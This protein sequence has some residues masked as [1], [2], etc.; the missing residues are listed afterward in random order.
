MKRAFMIIG[1]VFLLSIF[2]RF[3]FG[4]TVHHV[5]TAAE[6]HNAL[7]A[8]ATNGDDDNIQVAIGTY[9]GNFQCTVTDG[10]DI[11]LS[12]GYSHDFYS[13]FSSPSLTVLDGGNLDKVLSIR[14][15][16]GGSIGVWRFT[17][18]NGQYTHSWYRSYGAGISAYAWT[19]IDG[20][21]S[22]SIFIADNIIIGNSVT[23]GFGGGVY[24]RSLSEKGPTGYIYIDNNIIA[25]NTAK[26]RGGGIEA[27]V[28]SMIGSHGDV[29]FEGNTITANACTDFNTDAG[30]ARIDG[31]NCFV[32]N[33]IIW[34]N[35]ALR[36]GDLFISG[37]YTSGHYNDYDPAKI[38]GTWT[39]EGN[40]INVDPLFVGGGD[41]HLLPNS[42][43]IDAGN[44]LS[45][46]IYDF[47][48]NLRIID[49]NRDGKAKEDIGA[50]EYIPIHEFDGHDFDGNGTSDVSVWRPYDGKWYIRGMT[51]IPWGIQGDIPVNGY[52]NGDSIT[53]IA[54]WRPSNG[55]WY[56]RGV[57]GTNWG[58]AGDIPVPADYNGDGITEKAVWRPSNGRWYVQG[59]GS[60]I[61]GIH[62]DIPVPGDYNGDGISEI[63]V[64][65]PSNGR[66]YIRGLGGTNW[67]Q[68]GD[69]PVPADYNGD[70]T[71]DVAVWRPLDGRWYI[72]G[73]PGI[74]WGV[75]GD[76]P[77][78]GDYN[79]DGVTD[80][81]VWRPPEGKWFIKGQGMYIWG[82]L[83]S[84]VPW[85]DIPLVR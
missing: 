24:A 56:I 52:Y 80:I 34:G 18:R 29:Y 31:A 68:A 22:G 12:G 39:S 37:G 71:T 49:G 73:L 61:W 69:F 36:G 38:R 27:T 35:T 14:T 5:T 55:R 32:Y 33:N 62:G 28:Y 3:S 84:G 19:N 21:Y 6:L 85:G 10:K 45:G 40:N 4:E 25:E 9:Y 64:W 76:T 75:I 59:V 30:G 74:K 15:E 51:A 70:G 57:G 72:H 47:E 81:A 16:Q 1:C 77:T 44:L 2:A 79:G 53:D 83:V 82:K 65:R 41:Y 7:A 58:Q 26:T 54:V 67:G 66:W 13:M 42:P 17:I 43:C 11:W 50:D 48:L 8:A 46:F 63:A 20:A 60:Y 23:E 78:P